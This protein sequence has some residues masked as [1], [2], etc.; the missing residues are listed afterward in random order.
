MADLLITAK[1]DV[2]A[3][4]D[5]GANPLWLASRNRNPAMI[6]T[7]LDAGANPNAMLST[8]ETPLMQASLAGNVASVRALLAYG[9]DVDAHETSRESDGADVGGVQRSHRGRLCASGGR[10]R[11]ARA[12]V[13][14]TADGQHGGSR[15]RRLGH[16]LRPGRR[17]RGG[18]R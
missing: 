5:L 13:C 9:V 1:A 10:G 12:I 17:L 6:A 2:N 16:G 11:R 14:L 18:C 8:G 7:L 3:S 4:N 15:R